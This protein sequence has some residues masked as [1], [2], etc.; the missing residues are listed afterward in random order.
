MGK[1]REV[2]QQ[3]NTE[4]QEVKPKKNSRI[5]DCIP[6]EFGLDPPIRSKSRS[7]SWSELRWTLTV[8]QDAVM[9]GAIL[10]AR[11][12]FAE[13]RHAKGLEEGKREIELELSFGKRKKKNKRVKA[14]GRDGYR[15]GRRKAAKQTP[16]KLIEIIDAFRYRL[17]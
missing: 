9:W 16:P 15:R 14:S 7:R 4:E 17:P 3:I 5:F 12:S 11:M 6:V 10:A 13:D 8:F 1:Y 2:P